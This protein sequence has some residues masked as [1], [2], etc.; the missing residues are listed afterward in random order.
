LEINLSNREDTENMYGTD[1]IYKLTLKPY[2][3]KTIY[4]QATSFIYQ[5]YSIMIFDEK[6]SLQHLSSQHLPIIIILSILIGLMI[7][8]FILYII[9]FFKDYLY[10]SLYLFFNILWGSYE[11][12][13]MSKYFGWYGKDFFIFDLMIIFAIIFLSLFIKNIIQAPKLYP[14]EN[15]LINLIIS[16]FILNFGYI[17]VDIYMTLNL[18]VILMIISANI[19]IG[20]LISLYIKKDRYISYILFAQIWFMF[21]DLISLAFYEGFISYNFWTRYSYIL[22]IFMDTF[23]FSFLLSHR[24]RL[25]QEDNKKNIDQKKRIEGLSELLENISHQWRQPLTKINSSIMNIAIELK[26]GKIVNQNIDKKLDDIE[27]LSLYLSQTID[28]FKSL[29]RKDREISKFNLLDAINSS[30]NLIDL[31]NNIEIKVDRSKSLYIDNYLNE[32][33]QVLQVILN[34]AKDA[35]INAKNKTP[36]IKIYAYQKDKQTIIKISNNGGEIKESILEN[37]FDA[38]FSTKEDG[39][40]IGLFMSQKILKELMSAS[41][42]CQNIKNGVCFYIEFL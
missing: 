25:L 3:T 38:H 41:L 32:F 42:Y 17:F 11:Y 33:Q 8:H 27:N 1:A 6:H 36:Y 7:Y 5:Y 24:I 37:I 31:D 19:Y 30:L 16:I 13:I 22:G 2:E 20:I 39:E 23:A 28:D 12:G 35:L 40:G 15:K 34:N 14:I 29:Y 9:T 4:I 18:F 26:K 10:Y 21:F